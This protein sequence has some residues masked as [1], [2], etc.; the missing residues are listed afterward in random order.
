MLFKANIVLN[1][2]FKLSNISKNNLIYCKKFI[3]FLYFIKNINNYNFK[4]CNIYKNKKQ[5][6]NYLKAP[7]KNKMARNQLSFSNNK[8]RI[9][10][11]FDINNYYNI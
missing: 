3:L 2:N 7:Y 1:T 11:S 9:F 4:I 5:T 8:V 6:L 10:I